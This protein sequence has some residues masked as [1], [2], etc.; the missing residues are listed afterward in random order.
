MNRRAAIEALIELRGDVGDLTS[1]AL[2]FLPAPL[3]PS[4]TLTEA[5]IDAVLDRY[6]RGTL[7][8]NEVER[9]ADAV[10]GRDDVQ[11]RDIHAGVISNLLFRLSTP[12]INTPLTHEVARAMR[13]EIAVL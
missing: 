13:H 4:V 10:E 8:A 6:L 2:A 11:Y 7:S 1:A 3:E 5:H 9:W 12:E